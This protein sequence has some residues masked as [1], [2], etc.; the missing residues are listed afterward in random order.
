MGRG[1]E[2]ERGKNLD[3]TLIIILE[4]VFL[5]DTYCVTSD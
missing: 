5:T 4:I 3:N 1:K 2:R